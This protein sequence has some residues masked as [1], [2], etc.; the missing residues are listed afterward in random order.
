MSA[1]IIVKGS[2][3]NN[4][5]RDENPFSSNAF[6]KIPNPTR[7]GALAINVRPPPTTLPLTRAI[8]EL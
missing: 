5:S 1:A 7:L 3:H 6:D 4:N 8:L 2:D